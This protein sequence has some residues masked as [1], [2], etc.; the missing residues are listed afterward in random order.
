MLPL[1]HDTWASIQDALRRRAGDAAYDAWLSGLRPVSMERGIVWLEAGSRL[2]ADR[3]RALYRPLLE[4]V[5]SAEIGTAVQVDL[6]AG[7][8]ATPFHEVEV[9]PQQPI[10]DD[11]NRTAFLVLE[12]LASGRPLPTNRF[13]LHGSSGVGKTFLLRWWQQRHPQRPLAF[14]LP[15]LLRAF[16]AVHLDGRVDSFHAELTRDVPLV[17][18]ELHRVAGKPKLQQ[19]L[20]AVLRQRETLASPTVMASRWHPK[21]IHDLDPGLATLLLAGFVAQID[22]PGPLARLRYL[23][24]L[25]GAPS[26]NGRADLVESLAQRPVASWRELRGLWLAQQAA[27]R[28]GEPSKYLE[29]IDPGRVFQRLLQRVSERM[30]LSAEEVLGKSQGRLVSMARKVLAFLCVQE[31]LSRAEVGRYFGRRSRAAISYLTRSL[32]QQM[33]TSPSV[34]ALVEGML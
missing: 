27:E 31:G 11:G 28:G 25:V 32:E 4:D 30:G 16:Q 7:S 23:R 33:A 1:L 17:L 21:E 6:Q 34:R 29:L 10:V 18:D 2:A 12:S 26:R 15:A 13:L 14:E 20:A 19:F 22:P 8:E 5:L 9:S 3:V 24:A